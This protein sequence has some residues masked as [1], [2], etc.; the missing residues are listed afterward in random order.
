MVI[1]RWEDSQN[2]VNLLASSKENSFRLAVFSKRLDA[3]AKA[4][5]IESERLEKQKAPQ[6]DIERRKKETDELEVA[7]QI[8]LEIFRP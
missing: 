7:R 2:S 5:I 1:A 8:N 3:Q 6:V 4:A